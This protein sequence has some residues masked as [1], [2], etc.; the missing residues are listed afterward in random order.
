MKKTAYKHLY[1]VQTYGRLYSDD[2]Q[3]VEMLYEDIL[4]HDQ[5]DCWIDN[6]E[7]ALLTANNVRI[8]DKDAYKYDDHYVAILHKEMAIPDF[9]N[10]LDLDF[11]L[12]NDDVQECLNDFLDYSWEHIFT[13]E[14]TSH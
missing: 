8:I 12:S 14:L 2:K 10:D 13:K 11:D 6:L 5:N 3:D 9:E 4:T 7:L 1:R